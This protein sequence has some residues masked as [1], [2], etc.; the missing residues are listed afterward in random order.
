VIIIAH[1]SGSA[2]TVNR[3]SVTRAEY[4][5]DFVRG[6]VDD[7]VFVV[8]PFARVLYIVVEDLPV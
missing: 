3:A 5:A 7:D 8:V 4:A 2:E 1:E 6:F